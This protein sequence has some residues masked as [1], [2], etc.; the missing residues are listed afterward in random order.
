V[1]DDLSLRV[2]RLE[3]KFKLYEPILTAM[4]RLASI[5]TE[6]GLIN[7]D[8]RV[9]KDSKIEVRERLMSLIKTQ[10][11]GYDA[12]VV[13][14][15]EKTQALEKE[16]EDCPIKDAL[17]RLGVAEKE[18][19]VIKLLNERMVLVEKALDS[20]KLKGWDLVY[21]IIPWILAAMATGWALLR[22]K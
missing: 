16:V 21:R 17:I 3:D 1:T 19:A 20:I 22:P 9:L 6:L 7:D 13:K 18:I 15:E 11:Q 12:I 8:L 5:P 10:S 4:P 2:G 14:L